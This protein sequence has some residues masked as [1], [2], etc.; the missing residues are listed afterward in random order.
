MAVAI[1]LAH[2]FVTGRL[3]ESRGAYIVDLGICLPLGVVTFAAAASLLG[4]EEMRGALRVAA[5]RG[6]GLMLGVRARILDK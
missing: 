5:G 4:I 1:Y 2:R 3:G 6:R